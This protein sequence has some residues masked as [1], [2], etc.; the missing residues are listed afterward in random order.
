VAP[1]VDAENN[2]EDSGVLFRPADAMKPTLAGIKARTVD[3]DSASLRPLSDSLRCILVVFVRVLDALYLIFWVERFS[4]GS[5]CWLEKICYG[6][7]GCHCRGF[8]LWKHERASFGRCFLEDGCVSHGA[9]RF[10]DAETAAILWLSE[11]HSLGE[12][13]CDIGKLD[14][15]VGCSPTG[16]CRS[17]RIFCMYD[18]SC[19]AVRLKVRM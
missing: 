8:F 15:F 14:S 9:S 5:C 13:S 19:L 3:S 2:Q 1:K 18:D 6:A 12:S 17:R 10:P 11:T 16:V 7:I 4:P